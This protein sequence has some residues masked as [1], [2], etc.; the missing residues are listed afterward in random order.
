MNNYKLICTGCNAE[1][2]TKEMLCRCPHCGE[3]LEV[4]M[5]HSGKISN[6]N[7][8]SE[9]SLERYK[10]FFPFF[11]IDKKYLLGEGFTPLLNSDDLAKEAGVAEL[12]FKNETV[13]PTWSF[14]DR[15]TVTGIL[16]AISNGFDKI[17]TVST[18]N[19]AVSVAAYGSHANLDTYVLVSKSLPP[20]KLN[21]IAIYG[22]HLIKVDGDYGK[23]YYD[24]LKIGKEQGI[25]FINSDAPFRVVGYKTLA[26]EICEQLNFDIPDY[27]VVPT[28]AG[29]HIRAIYRGFEEFYH[30]GYIK[31]LPKMVC[32][33]AAGCSPIVRAFE[34]NED[35][36]TRFE[37]PHT[38]A[39]AIENPLPPSGNETLRL[40]KKC[41]G[42][43]EAVTE[44]EILEA[45][46]QLGATGLFVQPASAVSYAAVKKLVKKGEITANDRVACVL[47][48]SGLKYTAVFE[49]H[50]LTCSE[51]KLE[52]LGE[53]FKNFSKK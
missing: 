23:L 41:N 25:C 10:D 47:T 38:I 19:M 48:G 50:H 28:S 27:V 2:S 39:H 3:P 43:A 30:S 8:L 21:P 46:R 14:K 52:D 42:L 44:D 51:T 34:K 20:E 33:Q 35:H 6:K 16:H 24:S 29:G 22:C 15:G 11:Q 37:N 17:G 12:Y 4:E 49:H 31:K 53:F 7:P 36:I 40:L 5:I 45:Q 1:Y 26:F 32:A 18:G 13:N 9:S